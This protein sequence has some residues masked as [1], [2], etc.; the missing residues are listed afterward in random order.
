MRRLIK[1]AISFAGSKSSFQVLTVNFFF[2]LDL[3][4]V[5]RHIN[6]VNNHTEKYFL[7]PSS[8]VG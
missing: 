5:C 8:K 6:T 4:K 3:F 7:S 2:A 1:T